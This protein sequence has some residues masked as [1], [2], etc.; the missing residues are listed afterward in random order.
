MATYNGKVALITGANAGI[1]KVTALE[2]AK[3]GMRI[4]MAC[5]NLETAKAAQESIIKESGNENVE[6]KRLDLGSLTSVNE[7]AD[8]IVSSVEKIDYLINNAGVMSLPFT[9]TVDGF[10]SHIGINHFGHFLLTLRL[11]DLVKKADCARIVNVSSMAG[12]AGKLRFDDIHFSKGSYWSY[13]AYAQSKLA[14]MLFT[15]EL[16]QRLA[17]TNVTAYAVHPGVVDTPLYRNQWS[18]SKVV[19]WPIKKLFMK[20]PEQGAETTL[21][22]VLEEGIEKLSGK[23][24]ADSKLSSVPAKCENKDHALR[25]WNL[26]MKTVGLSEGGE[27]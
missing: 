1:G 14:N 4:I 19:M 26:S 20:T 6:V 3:K 21:Y 9:L 11:L 27:E 5:R 13:T 8:E 2:L 12:K 25:L 22:C 17:D 10:E 15:F 7:F 16:A 23:Y 24:F 18:I